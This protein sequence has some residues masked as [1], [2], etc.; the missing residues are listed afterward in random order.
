MGWQPISTAPTQGRTIVDLWVQEPDGGRR[1]PD[2]WFDGVWM[3]FNPAVGY[4]TVMESPTHWMSP[5]GP[6]SSS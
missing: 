4:I 6:P 5:P 1:I 3:Y 2:C